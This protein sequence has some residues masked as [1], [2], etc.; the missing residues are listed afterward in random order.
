MEEGVPQSFTF[1]FS[2]Q[3]RVKAAAAGAA[4]R[5][6]LDALIRQ[7]EARQADRR[8]GAQPLLAP[9]PARLTPTQRW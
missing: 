3:A 4:Q 8:A 2:G 6:D 9:A 1:T 7:L 5:D